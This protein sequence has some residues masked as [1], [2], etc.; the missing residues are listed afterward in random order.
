[1]SVRK[2]LTRIVKIDVFF[3]DADI[4]EATASAKGRGN[5]TPYT[6]HAKA[7]VE[8][9]KGY[10]IVPVNAE[11][12][13]FTARAWVRKLNSELGCTLKATKFSCDDPKGRWYTG[14]LCVKLA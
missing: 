11:S 6:D 2:D 12:K 9:G 13:E 1:M 7:I 4:A 5:P 14:D 8:A 3:D 10:F